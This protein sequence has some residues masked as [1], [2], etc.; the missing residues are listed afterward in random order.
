MYKSI[1]EILSNP[2]IDSKI[3][4]KGWIRTKRSNGKISFVEINDGSNIKGIQAII[5]K[6]EIQ[7]EEKKLKKLT[8]GTSI[9]LTGILILSPS[10]GQTYEIKTTNFTIIGEADQETY[11]LQK[12]RHTFEFLREIPHLRIRTNTFGAVARI[13]NQISYKIHEYFQKNGF[14]YIHTPI[15]TSHDGEGAG[16]IFRV[17]TL[18][19][20]N[21]AKKK[22]INF[23]DDFFGKQ[24]F[25][26]VTGQLHGEAY[27]MALSKIY[28][29]GPTFRAENSNTTR[30]ASEFWMIEPEMAFFKL[31]DNINLAENFLKY[32]LRETLNNCSQDMEFFDNFIEK[33]LIKKIENVINSEFEIITY[34]Q[35]IKKLESATKTFEIK[36][37][38]GM[39]LQTE[40][41]RYLTEEIIKKPTT[42]IDYPKEFKAFYMKIN[43]D[44]KTVK[45]MDILVPRIGEIIGGS[46][47]E[48]NLDKLNKR[49]KELNLESETLNWYL[50]LRRFGSTPHSGF[51]LGLERLIQYTTGMANIRDVIPFPRTPKTLYF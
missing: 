49:I 27:A 35:A 30:H 2:K 8:T 34:T 22:E 37:Y 23:K 47:R 19:F 51:G 41:E 29:F 13:R 46:E 5:D 14:L 32:I 44:N 39:D 28:T 36:P 12:K 38:W 6:E 21:I 42:I 25:L 20:N 9:S 17:S 43:K 50:D 4:I 40:H 24:T 10:K 7:F 1:K 33:G 26:T 16:E 18:N 3:T 11:P 31:E 15:I 45:G 48:D